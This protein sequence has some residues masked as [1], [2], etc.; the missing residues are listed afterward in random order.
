[1]ATYRDLCTSTLQLAGVYGSEEDP[2][3]DDV[4]VTL[5]AMSDMLDGWANE[6]MMIPNE[7]TESVSWAS[8]ISSKSIGTGQVFNVLRPMYILS[9]HFRDAANNDYDLRI[10]SNEQFQRITQKSQTSGY[11]SYLMYDP[12]V[13]DSNEPDY[14][15]YG[16]IYLWPVPN[17]TITVYVTYRKEFNV[18]DLDSTVALPPGWKEAII[19]NLAQRVRIIFGRPVNPQMDGLAMEAK[20]KLKR[21][22]A[23]NNDLDEMDSGFSNNGR[24]WNPLTGYWA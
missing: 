12:F 23:Q 8:S 10:I 7:R 15:P 1:M 4:N 16:N 3:S 5:S 22:N 18:A 14:D 6:S 11:P 9:A 2:T 17:A 19:Y 20:A 13:G 21:T 24:A